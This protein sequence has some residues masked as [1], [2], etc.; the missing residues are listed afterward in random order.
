MKNYLIRSMLNIISFALV[1]I[2]NFLLPAGR[3]ISQVSNSIDYLFK[4]AG[5]AFMIWLVIYFLL[6]VWLMRQFFCSE[7]EKAIYKKIGYWFSVNMLLNALWVLAFGNEHINISLL[8]MIGILLTL[9]VV[10]TRIQSSPNK[11]KLTRLPISMYLGWISIAT[12]TNVFT[13]Y[14]ANDITHLLGLNE[15]TWTIIM[16]LFGGLLGAY[17]TLKNNDL[18]YP[19][20][21][22]WAYAAIIVQRKNIESIT[23]A[24]WIAIALLTAVTVY[25]GLR[26]KNV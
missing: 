4:P 18:V 3:N 22:I 14:K 6:A 1:L 25:N 19:L 15:L 7:I 10:Y 17:F 16:L 11:T 24:A 8:I 12:I 21:F 20:V 23:T 26:N 9:I 5:Y 2:T 13:V